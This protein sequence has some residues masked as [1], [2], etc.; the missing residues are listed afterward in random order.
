MNGKCSAVDSCVT[1]VIDLGS[2]QACTDHASC[3]P[4]GNGFMCKCDNGY[5][6]VDDVCVDI[7]ETQKVLNDCWSFTIGNNQKC[8]KYVKNDFPSTAKSICENL[9]AKVP[10][11]R[12]S[13]ENN[14]YKNAFRKLTSH[15][16]VALGLSD[17]A[18]EG[19][20][21]DFDGN[22]ATYTNWNDREPNNQGDEDYA[23]MYTKRTED[24]TPGKW[25]DETKDRY[26]IAIIC[27]ATATLAQST[28]KCKCPLLIYTHVPDGPES[29]DVR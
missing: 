18:S 16:Y 7:D 28:L 10:L 29:P 15:S 25:N 26:T 6:M 17:V 8:L 12:S 3:L 9:G 2:E 11:P 23:L 4:S 5:E 24:T 19:I 1:R 20:W 22:L 13:D 27:E 21:R 14:D